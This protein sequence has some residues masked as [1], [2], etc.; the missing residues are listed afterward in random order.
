[1]FAQSNYCMRHGTGRARDICHRIRGGRK[2]PSD[3][4]FNIGFAVTGQDDDWRWSEQWLPHASW[5]L[6]AASM[7]H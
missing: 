4:D 7:G 5:Y 1:M 3:I 6:Y 2:N